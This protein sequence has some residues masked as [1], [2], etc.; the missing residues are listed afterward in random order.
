MLKGS[1][2]LV[3]DKPL[4]LTSTQ[5][6]SL[7]RRALGLKKIGHVGTLDPLATGVLS[8]ALEE[9]TKIIPYY[10]N[11]LKTYDFEVTWGE[12]R[13]TDDREG[14]ILETSLIRPTL[15]Q[16][17]SILPKFIGEIEQLPPVFSAIKVGGRRAYQVA[18]SGGS[19]QLTPRK[20]IIHSLEVTKWLNVNQCQFRMVCG[21]GT[22]V[23]SLGRDIAIV[24]GTV[25]HISAL[26]RVEDGKFSITDAISLEKFKEIAHK[27][28]VYQYI[29][30]IGAV[31]DDIP[32]VS[33]SGSDIEKL[34]NGQK[35]KS[36]DAYKQNLVMLYDHQR[37]AA[38]A[39]LQDGYWHPKR[40]FHS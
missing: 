2:W 24:L 31:L 10:N 23:R 38:I 4:H 20:I 11:C 30:P 13:T 35:I 25:G 28:D 32:A 39:T 1:G 5:V 22:Y 33:V 9:A 16:I 7:V 15:D 37:L 17:Q 29:K 19:V 18:R 12:S 3:I 27:E 26:R 14:E 8:L 21:S 40:V 34:R 6:G 36:Y